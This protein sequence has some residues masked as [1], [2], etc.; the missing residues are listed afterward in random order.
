MVPWEIWVSESQERMVLAVSPEN[1][2]RTLAIFRSWDV[3]ATVIGQVTDT[4]RTVLQFRGHQVCDL[5]LEFYTGAVRYQREQ[6][7]PKAEV[8]PVRAAPPSDLNAALLKLLSSPN[9]ASREY[10]IRQY[11]HE[12]RANT[13]LKPLQGNLWHPGHG[14][15]AVLKPLVDSFRGLALT[16]D[17]NPAMTSC[18]AYWGAASAL[19][20]AFRN[21]VAVGAKP[22]CWADN[23]NFGNPEKPERM[24]EFQ[25]ATDGLYF[26]AKELG[27]PCVSGNVSFY[28]ESSAG[29]IPP[30]P[31]IFAIGMVEDV[32]KCVTSDIK[33]A[34][35][36][37][38]ILGETFE[39]MGGS[40][41]VGYVLGEPMSGTVPQVDPPLFK[42]K[43]ERLLRAIEAGMVASCHDLS[44]GGLGIAIAEM[45]I[46]GGCG[47]RLD[48][49]ELTGEASRPD[50]ILFSE[51][52]GRWLAEV[53][54]DKVKA[55]EKEMAPVAC[56]R[57]G[58]TTEEAR[59]L[60]TGRGVDIDLSLDEIRERWEKGLASMVGE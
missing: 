41:Y 30:T 26:V 3:P 40:E 54:L 8:K 5:D 11:D 60:I 57:I 16:A 56:A 6:Q 39:E 15:A 9:L 21:L 44:E 24:W 45:L 17:V 7:M 38:Y 35:N 50:F 53:R 22:H 43:M 33:G 1:V 52:N 28:N 32:R 27:V 13:V 48:L 37:I 47:C 36:F 18:D 2:E 49:S 55:F 19:E 25:A 29:S 4:P 42:E 59:L 46:G 10:I 23:L 31:T 58:E 14:D 34:G 51:S 12:V 20:E